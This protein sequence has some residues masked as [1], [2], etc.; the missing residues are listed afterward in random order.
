MLKI[1]LLTGEFP[2][3]QGGVGAFTQALAVA[4]AELGQEIYIISHRE[5]RPT[6]RSYKA[7]ELREPIDLG[8]AKLL[9]RGRKW[10][11]KDNQMIASMVERYELDILNIQ[12]QPAAFNMR[13][14]AINLLPW[15]LRGLTH[16]VVTFHDLRTP[17]LFPKAGR[18]RRRVVD[19]MAEK[20]EGVIVTNQ[21]DYL[22]LAQKRVEHLQKI[23]IGS[24]IAVHDVS[25]ETRAHTRQ[26]LDLA[27]TD[28][29]LAYFGFL[30]TSKGADTLIAALAQLPANFHLLFV[31]G[32]TGA[33]DSS[34]NQSFLDQIKTQVATAGLNQ[35]VHWTGFVQDEQVSAFLKSAEMI[36]LPYH[37]G[38][39]LRRGT[40]MAALAHG[41]P[42]ITTPPRMA[43]VG[44]DDQY[45]VLVP[46]ADSVKLAEAI[47]ALARDEEKR[48][49]LGLGSAEFSQQFQW[50]K[51]AAQTI[52]FYQSL[53]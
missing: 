31:G 12:Y 35:R 3:M 36:V 19:F 50:S 2:P 32:Q 25:A 45:F 14:P 28:V 6:D 53:L 15:R 16:S 30:N 8:Y 4:L 39:S 17:F 1:G 33:S 51:I 43:E 49:A 29:L 23:P 10:D 26:S 27:P 13:R 34:N 7:R 52:Q 38:V 24:N 42:I 47:V 46:P 5:A 41:C 11:G 18:L 44:L 20:A 9:A 40:L 48:Q 37:D 21:Q 22:K